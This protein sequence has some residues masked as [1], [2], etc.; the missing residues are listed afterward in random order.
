MINITGYLHRDNFS[1]I[2]RRWMYHHTR[3]TDAWDIVRLVQF[4]NAFVAGYLND[5]ARRVFQLH[6]TSAVTVKPIATKGMLKDAMVAST[7]CSNPRIMEMTAGYRDEPGK[8][9]RET[10]FNG[11]LYYTQ[12]SAGALYIGSTRIKR[13]RRLAEKSARRIIDRIYADIKLRAEMLARDRA[14]RLGT[15]METL[16]TTPEEMI[17]EFLKAENRLLDDIKNG[18][19]IFGQDQLLIQDVAGM[20]IVVEDDQRNSFF[21][22]INEL[23][24]CQLIEIENHQG[25]YNAVNLIVRFEPD[26]QNLLNTPLNDELMA[27]MQVF[28]SSPDRIREQFREFIRSGEDHVHI[29]VIVSS[30]QEMLESEI[31]RCM[32]EDRILR[33]RL[34]QQYNSQ[35]ARNIEF[36]MA[37]LFAFSAS[38]RLELGE[39]PIRLWHCY[40][41][42]YF[43]EI[44]G[45]LPDHAC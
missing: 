25:A 26:R 19:P 3:P 6:Y 43:E 21:N 20:K 18:R 23:E 15:R 11:S 35:L 22:K 37:Y 38:R 36:L 1:N 10:P 9:Y 44:I 16:I 7:P 39:L 2:I 30:Y 31:G 13:V 27:C 4:N 17:A 40:L 33:Q 41:P 32:H 12:S 45:H 14:M 24:N 34:S 5:F 8:F 28:G 29:E 42:D